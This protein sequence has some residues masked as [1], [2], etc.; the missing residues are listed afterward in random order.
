MVM[1]SP[2]RRRL[3]SFTIGYLTRQSKI[4]FKILEKT[5]SEFSMNDR[6]KN[7]FCLPL[8]SP[9]MRH[10][11][12][13]SPCHG[14]TRMRK[15]GRDHFP[16]FELFSRLEFREREKGMKRIRE[17]AIISL[18]S[19]FAHRFINCVGKKPS[20][21]RKKAESVNNPFVLDPNE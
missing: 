17:H 16:G 11:S 5:K 18:R 15:M 6:T 13:L 1:F 20:S 10:L 8:R 2:R 12:A 19:R 3:A 14:K 7:W 21:R 9:G 4:C